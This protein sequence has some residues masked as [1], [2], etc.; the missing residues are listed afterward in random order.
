V[1]TSPVPIAQMGSYAM[2]IDFTCSTGMSLEVGLDL[3]EH[4]AHLVAGLADVQA[5]AAAEDRR[6]AVLVRR[7]DLGVDSSSV[8]WWYSR[9]SLCR[10]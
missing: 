2:T 4:V 9:R 10:R 8:S 3:G 6:Q 1:A 7:L 5:L